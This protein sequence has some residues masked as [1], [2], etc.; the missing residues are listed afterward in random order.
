M[1]TADLGA[2]EKLTTSAQIELTTPKTDRATRQRC[3]ARYII[4]AGGVQVAE[5]MWA[6]LSSA[7]HQPRATTQDG[8]KT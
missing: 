7:P 6:S 3:G 4:Q 2:H 1:V 5:E 8:P